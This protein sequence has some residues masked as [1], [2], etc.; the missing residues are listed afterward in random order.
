MKLKMS[1]SEKFSIDGFAFL[2]LAVVHF[3]M[4][5]RSMAYNYSLLGQNLSEKIITVFPVSREADT[6]AFHDKSF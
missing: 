2:L 1:G 6:S 3:V 5:L 4:V